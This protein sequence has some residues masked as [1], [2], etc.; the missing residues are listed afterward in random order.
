MEKVYLVLPEAPHFKPQLHLLRISPHPT[1][2]NKRHARR[3][4]CKCARM[5]TH[6]EPTQKKNSKPSQ[7]QIEKQQLDLTHDM[8]YKE[9]HQFLF[10][11]SPLGSKS[12]NLRTTNY[13]LRKTLGIRALAYTPR[14]I[15]LAGHQSGVLRVRMNVI[16][17]ESSDVSIQSP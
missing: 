13:A 16:V 7:L 9:S 12:R 14:G 10:L 8:T 17:K 3:Q 4:L 6:L 1:F 2:G 15:E 5:C 11:K